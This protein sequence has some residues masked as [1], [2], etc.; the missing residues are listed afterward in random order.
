MA[1]FV[2]PAITH[3]RDPQVLFSISWG[4]LSH[5]SGYDSAKQTAYL[6]EM[7]RWGLD[8]SMRVRHSLPPSL[9]SPLALTLG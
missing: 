6:D 1:S 9:E 2:A 8:W 4:A 7:L 3:T 5:G